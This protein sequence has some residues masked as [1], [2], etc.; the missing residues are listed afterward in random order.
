[1]NSDH[2]TC[3][4]PD[5]DVPKLMCGFPLPCPWHTAIIHADRTP[6]TVEI[7]IARAVK[8]RPDADHS[9]SPRQDPSHQGSTVA[10]RP[11]VRAPRRLSRLVD[12]T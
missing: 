10:R 2:R 12:S 1:M 6:P 7:A 5:R 11:V 8:R 4:H 9:T 3:R